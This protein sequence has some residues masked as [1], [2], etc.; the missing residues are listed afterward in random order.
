M[1]SVNRPTYTAPIPGGAKITTKSVQKNGQR[2]IER[3]ATFKLNGRR[4]VALI[5]T[6][7]KGQD[8]CRI[9]SPK[10]Y[11]VW[12]DEHGKVQ[13]KPFATDKDAALQ[14]ARRLEKAAADKRAGIV[15]KY[16]EHRLRPIHE[17]VE[18]FLKLVGGSKNTPGHVRYRR[19]HLESLIEH[20]GWKHL[21]DIDET[22]V[23]EFLDQLKERR[24][25]P[26]QELPPPVPRPTTTTWAASKR[27]RTGSSLAGCPRTRWRP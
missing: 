20:A 23:V 21:Q 14:E 24:P 19:L 26:G 7:A 9:Q 4:V 1:A 25:V 6:D 11:A 27:S 15:D 8:R 13:R 17:H 12:K 10:W 22:D 3:Y 5:V 2:I 18:D 16:A